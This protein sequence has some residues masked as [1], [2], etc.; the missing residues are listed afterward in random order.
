MA[1]TLGAAAVEIIAET[2]EFDD[3]LRRNLAAAADEAAA[4]IGRNLRS[5]RADAELTGARLGQALGAGAEAA[6]N[7]IQNMRRL[8]QEAEGALRDLDADSLDRIGREAS[9]AADELDALARAARAGEGA[10]SG[11]PADELERIGRE[12]ENAARDMRRLRMESDDA[13][14]TIRRFTDGD[15]VRRLAED[16]RQAQREADRLGRTRLQNLQRDASG[17][18]RAIFLAFR[19]ASSASRDALNEIDNVKFRNLVRRAASTA[20]GIR[21]AFKDADKDADF[22]NSAS[23]IGKS[24]RTIVAAGAGIGLLAAR[25]A[26]LI[27]VASAVGAAVAP[28][29]EILAGL[30]ATILLA[31]GAI[32]VLKVGLSGIGDAFKAALGDDAKAFEESLKNLAPAAQNVA[33]ELRALKPALSDLK[34]SVQGALFKPLQGDLTAVV[35][36]LGGPLKAGMTATAAQFGRLG[37]AIADFGKSRSAVGLVAGVF[38]T[39]KTQIGSIKSGTITGLLKAISAFVQQTLPGFSNLGGGIDG[40]LQKLTAFLNKAVAGGKAFSWLQTGKA[41]VGQLAGI[42][43]DLGATV[44]NVFSAIRDAGGGSLTAFSNLAQQLRDLSASAQGQT[45]LVTIFQAVNAIAAQTFPVIKALIAGLGQLAPTVQQLALRVGPILTD[46]IAGVVPAIQA[47]GQGLI[48]VFDAIGVAVSKLAEG[49]GL[50]AFGQAIGNLLVAVAPLIPAIAD[51]ANA[52]F[53]VLNPILTG[54]APVINAIAVALAAIASSPLAPFLGVLVAQFALVFAVTGKAGL[55]FRSLG[56]TLRLT[57]TLLRLAGQAV[58]FLGRALITALIGNPVVAA[59]VAIIAVLV[60]AYFKVKVF[61]DIVNA[62]GSAL[63]TAG[64]AILGF[65]KSLVEAFQAGGIS[66]L[67][68]KIGSSLGNLGGIIGGALGDLGGFLL[69]KLQSG[70]SAVIGF[71]TSLPGKVVSALVTFGPQVLA[72]IGNGLLSVLTFLGTWAIKFLLFFITLPFKVVAAIIQ[73]GPTVLAAIASGLGQVL[74]FIA[75]FIIQVVA[76]FITLPFRILGALLSLALFLKQPFI[77]GVTAVI[78]FLGTA[79]AAIIAFFT[80]L[81]GRILAGIVALPGLLRSAAVSAWNAFKTAT[82]TATLATI[83]FVKALPGRVLAGLSA[84]GS[85]LARAAS[86]AWNSFKARTIAGV[87]AAIAFIRTLPSKALAALSSFTTR[88]GQLGRDIMTGLING[89]RA[90]AGNLLSAITGPINDAIGKAKSLLGIGSPSKVFHKIGSDTMQGFINGTDSKS[91]KAAAVFRKLIDAVVSDTGRGFVKAVTSTTAKINST[92]KNLTDDIIKA[93]KGRKTSID[94]VLISTI[95]QTNKTLVRL[96]AKRDK[97]ADTIKA[98]T[99]KATE[100]GN[101]ARD[102]ASLANVLS[103]ID[104]TSAPANATQV[105]QGLDARL[106]LIKKFRADIND[107][108]KRGLNTELISQI[109]AAGVDQGANLAAAL[110]GA[111]ADQIKDLNKV[112]KEIS[113]ASTGLG[114]DTADILFDSGKNAGKGFLA[115]L[116]SEQAEIIKLMTDLAQQ[117]AKTVK[118]TLKIGSPSK[119]LAGLGRDT[120]RGFISGVDRLAPRVE[121]ALSD[122]VSARNLQL[123]DLSAAAAGNAIRAQRFAALAAD[124]AAAAAAAAVPATGSNA[125]ATSRTNSSLDAGRT[126]RTVEVNAPINITMPTADPLAT[127]RAVSEAIAAKVNR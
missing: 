29:A 22:S 119:V 125:A 43:A 82:I 33:K 64:K 81:P 15:S 46:A 28:S 63:L 30:P 51:L 24:F 44:L 38:G 126:V 1:S 96:A 78:S 54:L 73:F 49:G 122:A 21:K 110:V 41:A 98:A 90:L 48:P 36:N 77:N 112:Q 99:A 34:K 105:A 109:A 7:Q 80:A 89:I 75:N 20:G 6:G 12:A 14:G 9:D 74:F 116:K 127:G 93:F 37:S 83:A 71:F 25:F 26:S 39:L 57:G 68:A 70:F 69:G 65:G 79:I 102:F 88:M 87:Q 58:L 113:K 11:R 59:I 56:P 100:I 120:L 61:R 5:I 60:I 32:A 84:L 10:F 23:R 66:G 94:N 18:A 92:F 123:P 13:A 35:K 55:A 2:D 47:I 124:R 53:A 85:F 3:T 16:L 103:E 8:A 31:A 95:D 86:S 117:V 19:G 101:A 107:L 91:K 17:T 104:Q 118:K 67:I 97:I 115:G 52:G 76:F 108:A 114:K 4:L 42:V 106:R 27:S 45:Q 111:T 62:I 72:A 50:T 121:Q 40:A